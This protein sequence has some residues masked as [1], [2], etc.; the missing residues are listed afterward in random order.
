MMF[1]IGILLLLLRVLTVIALV[2]L[3][4]VIILCLSNIRAS[5]SFWDGRL[6][7]NIRYFGLKLLPRKSKPESETPE[8][9]TENKKSGRAEKKESKTE[10]SETQ[11]K[12]F[13]DHIL[14]KFHKF[15][16]KADMAGSALAALPPALRCFRKAV[17]WYA[18]ETDILIAN[19]DAADCARQYGLIQLI[20]QNL[21]GQVGALIHVRQKKIRISCDFIED[22]SRYNFRCKVK[23]N[24]GRTILTG[25]SFLWHYL[26]DSGTA[27]KSIVNPKL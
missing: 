23:I 17:T 25:I 16:K 6:D 22:Q 27:K 3:L 20:V 1:F 2:L 11:K 15:V 12:A 7:W 19:E 9:Q 10:K 24:V 5:V 13:M 26:K 21:F 14:E 4:L 18:I 8:D